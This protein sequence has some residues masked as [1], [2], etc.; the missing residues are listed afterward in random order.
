MCYAVRD[1]DPWY[2]FFWAIDD[3]L[4]ANVIAPRNGQT[5]VTLEGNFLLEERSG[6]VCG[7]GALPGADKVRECS[8][9]D[10]AEVYLM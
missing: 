6:E 3:V 8:G 2:K 1:D 5:E 7:A 10:E 9:E 4:D